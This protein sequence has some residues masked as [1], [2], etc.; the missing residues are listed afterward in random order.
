MSR[1]KESVAFL[2]LSA[3]TW[4]SSRS[5]PFIYG[6]G[7]GFT[8]ATVVV[9]VTGTHTWRG[10]VGWAASIGVPEVAFAP[11]GLGGRAPRSS[12]KSIEPLPSADHDALCAPRT[13]A[14]FGIRET[15]EPHV[16]WAWGRRGGEGSV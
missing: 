8:V 12:V 10:P 6:T 13:T 3:E 5:R 9:L 11:M 2:L 14:A 1:C 4:H 16:I 7:G 15:A